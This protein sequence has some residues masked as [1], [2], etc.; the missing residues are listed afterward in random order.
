VSGVMDAPMPGLRALV[1]RLRV[2]VH[3]RVAPR[4]PLASAP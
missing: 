3:V 1:V 4:V 2:L